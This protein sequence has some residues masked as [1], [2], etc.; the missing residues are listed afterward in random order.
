MRL[1]QKALLA[2]TSIGLLGVLT[3][4]PARAAELKAEGTEPGISIVIQDLKRD[5]S[6]SVTLRFQLIN[7]S[8]KS[9]HAG[10]KWREASNRA[11]EEIGGVHLI[12]NANKKKYLVVRD[13]TGKCACSVMP[14]VKAGARANLWAKFAAPPANV[15]KITVVVPDFQP[16]DGVPITP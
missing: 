13:N 16:I 4:A 11:C 15:E 6:N 14:Q 2:L 1:F 9:F 12:D 3:V 5:E 10:C 7:D 8:G